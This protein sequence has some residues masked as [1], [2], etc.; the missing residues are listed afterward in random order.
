[1]YIPC[2]IWSNI[3][4]FPPWIFGTISQA[5]CTPPARRGVISSSPSQDINY[6]ITGRVNTTCELLSSSPP[7]DTRNNIA[8]ELYPSCDIGSNIIHT[9]H[10]YQEQYHRVAVHSLLCLD[11][12]HTLSLF[13]LGSVSR[14]ECTPTAILKL[15]SCSPSLDIRNS[16]TGRCTPPAV[17]G[18]LI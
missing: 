1:M 14:G 5:G 10:E 6:N 2:H 8:E 4:R 7:P 16:I 3:N 17:L 9:F 13:I 12:C 18:V 11:S 15:K